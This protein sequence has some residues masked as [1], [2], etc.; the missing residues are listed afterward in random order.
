MKRKNLFLVVLILIMLGAIVLNLPPI[1]EKI[2]WRIDELNTRIFYILN[3]PEAVVFVPEGSSLTSTKTVQDISPTPDV[4]PTIQP[5]IETQTP[6]PTSPPTPE[7]TPLPPAVSLKGVRYMDQHG[8][9]NYCAPANLAMELSYWGWGGNREDTGKYLKPNPEDYNVMLYEMASYVRENTNLFV[10]LRYG[11]TLTL[12]KQLI[13]AGYP[14]LIEKGTY[15][16]DLN[17]KVSWMGHYNVVTGY[18]DAAQQI[19]VQDSYF[20]PNFTVKYD[21]LIQ[22][23]RSFNYGFLVV[24][25]PE[26]EAALMALLG[27][28]AGETQSNQKAADLA[29]VEA[30]SLSGVDQYFALFN[31]GTSLVALQDYNGAA[32]VYDQAFSLYPS[33]PEAKRP[34]RMMWYQTGPYFAY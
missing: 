7:P 30:G 31:R 22:E 28:Y 19:I 11:G 1:K 21:L 2:S 12:L 9:F 26:K 14:I 34:F 4:S 10:T 3:P 15:I 18:D 33:L 20:K 29:S 8:A 16:R 17:G 23:W 27:D 5:T 6:E 13:A 25:P 24:Y 32:G